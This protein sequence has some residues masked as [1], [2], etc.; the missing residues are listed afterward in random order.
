MA[1]NTAVRRSVSGKLGV[2]VGIV[3]VLTI[4]LIAVDLWLLGTVE[5]NAAAMNALAGGRW[6]AYRMMSLA[7]RIPGEAGAERAAVERELRELILETDRRY[8]QLREGDPAEGIPRFADPEILAGLRN[9]E[10]MWR[11]RIR[12]AFEAVAAAADRDAALRLL[13]ALRADLRTWFVDLDRDVARLQADSQTAVN[14]FQ[15]AQYA[16]L[17]AVV[18][19]LGPVLVLAR[20]VADRVR[21]LSGTAERI[22]AGE[23]AL[24]AGVGGDDELAALGDSFDKMTAHLRRTIEIEKEGRAQIE[25]LLTTVAETVNSLAAA[26]AEILASTAE[27]ASGVQEQAAAV[28]QTVSTVNEVLQTSDEAARRGRAVADSSQRAL[29][30]GRNGRRNV[31]DTISTLGSVRERSEAVAG[32]ILTLAERAQA[33]GEIIVAVNDIAEQTN[34]LA[35][36]AAIEAS[37]A[38]EHGRG[39][40]VVASE[41]RALAEQSKRATAQVRQILGEIQKATH[42]A[43]IATEESGKSISATMKVAGQAGETIKMLADTLAEAAQAAAQIAAA[44]SQQATGMSQVHT[45]MKNIDVVTGQNLTATRQTEKAAQD[46]NALGRKLKELLAGFGR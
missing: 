37:R 41:V 14:R 27:Q 15:L 44:S 25:R 18:L 38:G 9:R 23:L 36:N 2:L 13:P 1:A 28:A 16:Y 31:D 43:V 22:A 8:A 46:L 29:E 5:G 20:S 35:L 17:G 40:S 21:R 3:A 10:T 4:G 6:M 32:N 19:V 33:I 12:P 7:E 45:S 30:V 24:T 39:F 26:T 11:D 42:S 34:L